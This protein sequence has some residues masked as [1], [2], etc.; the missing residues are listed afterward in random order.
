MKIIQY[1]QQ[2]KTRFL[3]IPCILLC[4]AFGDAHNEVDLLKQISIT[5]STLYTDALN[6]L[7]MLYSEINADSSF[8]Y[9]S[10]A[11]DIAQQLNYE[12][13][14]ADAANNLGILLDLKGNTQQALRYYSDAYN[15]YTQMGDVSNMIQTTLNIAIVFDEM[16]K[17]PKALNSFKAAFALSKTLSKD[18]IMSFVY[19]N[20]VSSFSGNMPTDSIQFYISKSRQIAAKYKDYRMLLF[21]DQLTAEN[22]AVNNPRK[23]IA[24]LQATL[25]AALEKGFYYTA[26]DILI[27]LGNI[28]TDSA[29]AANYYL[30][31]LSLSSK[32][33]F[34]ESVRYAYEKL[35]DFYEAKGDDSASLVYA[36]KL[37]YFYDEQ[38]NLQNNYGIDY[39]DY[40]LKNKELTDSLTKLKLQQRLF[41]LVLVICILCAAFLIMLWRYT[42]KLKKAGNALKLQFAQAEQTTESLDMVNKNYSRVI[43]MVAHDLR[44]PISTINMVSTMINPNT[45]APDE[46][47]DLTNIITTLSKNSFDLIDQLLNT[48]LS[49]EQQ[50]VRSKVELN[51]LLSTCVRLL[52]FKAKEKRQQIIVSGQT[53]LT[54]FADAD[55]LTRVINNIVMNA[56]KF[57]PEE[58]I[59]NIKTFLK[60]KNAIIAIVDKGIGIPVGL[61]NKVFDPFTSAKRPGTKGETTFGLGLYISKRIVEAHG[62]VIWFNSMPEN[63]TAFYIQLPLLQ[64]E[65]DTAPLNIE[66]V[67]ESEK[68]Q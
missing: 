38:E 24:I 46:V 4:C 5:D 42:T 49:E 21:A 64:K 17:M 31:S 29:K 65:S 59:I 23:A 53:E 37:L 22:I 9:A 50:I 44:N 54:L 47:E 62:G 18:S 57:S 2:M 60:G 3:L 55:K 40:A 41:V 6:R 68:K 11:R 39:T 7:A 10:K 51:S 30:Q 45:M 32:K 19:A 43:K 35:Y 48:N 14:A 25:Q 34:T 20:Y 15:R 27:D 63:G 8:Y 12:K 16:G 58:S 1:Y 26:T 13:G 52:N 36:Q 66:S 28:T 61:Q 33:G 56:I 67:H